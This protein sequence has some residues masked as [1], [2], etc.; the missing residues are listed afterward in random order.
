M[1]PKVP[2]KV[3]GSYPPHMRRYISQLNHAEQRRAAMTPHLRMQTHRYYLRSSVASNATGSRPRLRTTPT[4]QHRH[5][6][7]NQLLQMAHRH[8][9]RLN[10]SANTQV[11]SPQN[12]ASLNGHGRSNQQRFG[13]GNIPGVIDIDDD[14]DDDSPYY[15][16]HVHPPAL[17]PNFSLFIPPANSNQ[18][19][20]QLPL[21][22]MA[23]RAQFED[24]IPHQRP[25]NH[26][27]V[28]PFQNEISSVM[29]PPPSPPVRSPVN[30]HCVP[31]DR[32]TP[33]SQY[34]QSN[35]SGNKGNHNQP[36]SDPH[37]KP[38][39]CHTME[40]NPYD[41]ETV[42]AHYNQPIIR[43]STSYGSYESYGHGTVSYSR[44]RRPDDQE[45]PEA[46]RRRVET[47]AVG[48]PERGCT[49]TIAIATGE[50][51]IDPIPRPRPIINGRLLSDEEFRN[52][53]M[54]ALSQQI[55]NMP[56][57]QRSKVIRALEAA[58]AIGATTSAKIFVAAYESKTPVMDAPELNETIGSDDDN[59]GASGGSDENANIDSDSDDPEVIR[60]CSYHPPVAANVEPL[61]EDRPPPSV[62]ATVAA[63]YRSEDEQGRI[64]FIHV[65]EP[66]PNDVELQAIQAI[67][68]FQVHVHRL[69][70]RNMFP[71]RAP[72]GQ[73]TPVDC[74]FVNTMRFIFPAF[75]MFPDL[76][77]ESQ[78]RVMDE[79]SERR[80]E[81]LNRICAVR[82]VQYRDLNERCVICQCEFERQQMIRTLL[83]GHKYHLICIDT[84]CRTALTCP[85]CRRGVDGQEVSEE[86]IRR[87][88]PFATLRSL[89]FIRSFL[90]MRRYSYHDN[91]LL[92]YD[93]G[94]NG[95]R[96][97]QQ[98]NSGGGTQN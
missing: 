31:S 22:L 95:D 28:R 71:Q 14:D 97:E 11:R 35:S 51:P 13:N 8:P 66:D 98:G 9:L 63:V 83:C 73:L 88:P 36:S 21:D 18:T 61:P 3:E 42:R 49:S 96:Q 26:T 30:L 72:A 69:V 58:R 68:R 54:R 75:L 17:I 7:G 84:W 92:N 50:L 48:V 86:T 41:P 90:V 43:P 38:H 79:I 56:D 25:P 44:I 53:K 5:S 65:N 45:I 55:N 37:A 74:L 2:R 89:E 12:E 10:N 70:Q 27:L 34:V 94:S 39:S 85:V 33:E 82:R 81:V 59:A 76:L 77:S 23:L 19:R 62:A 87:S 78:H 20:E 1:S 40:S 52:F 46:K 29:T 57:E 15:A 93:T 91:T 64:P 4:I 32:N 16:P 60:C 24:Q 67:Q 47:I 6:P 80:L